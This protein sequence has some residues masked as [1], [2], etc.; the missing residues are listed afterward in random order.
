MVIPGLCLALL[1][2]PVLILIMT[3]GL[4]YVLDIPPVSLSHLLGN[5]GSGLHSHTCLP[6]SLAGGGGTGPG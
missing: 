6:S 3:W 2:P 4:S 1:I 5:L